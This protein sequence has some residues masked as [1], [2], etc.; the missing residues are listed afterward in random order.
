MVMFFTPE[1]IFQRHARLV[2]LRG[3]SIVLSLS[4]PFARAA[5]VACRAMAYLYMAVLARTP[6]AVRRLC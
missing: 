6:G 3:E 5:E 2:K 1:F 4:T